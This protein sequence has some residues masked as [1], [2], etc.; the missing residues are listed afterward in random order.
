MDRRSFPPEQQ[1]RARG[2]LYSED[3]ANPPPRTFF[4]AMV[5]PYL[6]QPLSFHSNWVS[7]KTHN[8][9]QNSAFRHWSLSLVPFLRTPWQ[10]P[11]CRLQ[12]L[13]ENENLIAFTVQRPSKKTCLCSP[14][15]AWTIFTPVLEQTGCYRDTIVT[16]KAKEFVSV[17]VHMAEELSR[18]IFWFV[19]F[20]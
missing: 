13:I 19:I 2:L 15:K 8:S 17:E 6:T 16:Q 11:V 1:G 3:L 10:N 18:I 4:H 9:L 5:L 20:Y 7:Y 14:G 12:D